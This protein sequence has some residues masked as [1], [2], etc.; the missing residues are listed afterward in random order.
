M[1]ALNQNNHARAYVQG[2]QPDLER[3]SQFTVREGRGL[4]TKPRKGTDPK[5][6]ALS[7]TLLGVCVLVMVIGLVRVALASATTQA[8][9]ANKNLHVQIQEAQEL[10]GNLQVEVSVLGRATRINKIATEQ[11]GMVNSIGLDKL[12]MSSQGTESTHVQNSESKK[13]SQDPQASSEMPVDP[14]ISS[15]E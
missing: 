3:R 5:F 6:F 13:D 1:Q 9:S 14:S 7:K 8:L 12:D 15:N 2:A 4:S 10:S 11:Y